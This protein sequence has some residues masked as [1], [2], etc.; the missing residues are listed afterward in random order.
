MRASPSSPP[1]VPPTPVGPATLAIPP[2]LVEGGEA[3]PQ[4]LTA[5]PAHARRGLRGP[6]AAA[7]YRSRP[8]PSRA[9]RACRCSPQPVPSTRP[10]S[11]RGPAAAARPQSRPRPSRAA[12]AGHS[13][14]PP[15]PLTSDE[16]AQAGKYRY[17]PAKYG[18]SKLGH[19]VP[20]SSLPID[21]CCSHPMVICSTFRLQPSVAF[22]VCSA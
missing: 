1:P 5:G 9:A 3:P 13:H 21:R 10:A 14:P 4:Q 6:D 15:V 18:G 7:H 20:A 17:L 11:R 12:R 8:R 16:D 19:N 22:S 2:T